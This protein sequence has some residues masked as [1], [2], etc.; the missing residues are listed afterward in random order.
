MSSGLFFVEMK[1]DWESLIRCICRNGTP[2]RLHII[3]LFLDDEIKTA[4]CDKYVPL[5]GLSKSDK[6]FDLKREIAVHRF[7]GYDVFRVA[8]AVGIFPSNII[9][10]ADTTEIKDQQRSVREWSEEHIGPIQSW[11]DFEKYPWPR[12]SD[13]NFKALEWMEKNLNQAGEVWDGM[14]IYVPKRE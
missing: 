14:K 8:S 3:E 4:I 9:K 13:V 1:P 11:A 2:D 6:D 10:A 5:E 12:V 7:L